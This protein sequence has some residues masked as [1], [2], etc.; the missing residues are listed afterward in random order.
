[1]SFDAGFAQALLD[2]ELAVPEG[3]IDPAGRPA[4][5][6]FDVYR[7]N[8]VASLSAALADGFPAVHALVGAD[9]FTAMAR[10]YVRAHPPSD[11]R[12]MY[13]G[14]EMPRFLEGFGPVAHLAYLPDV[15]RLELALRESYHAGDATGLDAEGL[16]ALPA[17]RLEEMR[18]PLVPAAR[19]IRSGYPVL[20]IWHKSR[21][22]N[23]P[24]PQAIGQDVLIARPG[25]DPAP[26]GLGPGAFAF[27]SALQGGAVLSD[28]IA[29]A[30]A[31]A[32][33][34]DLSAALSLALTT[35]VLQ[36][37]ETP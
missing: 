28:A 37:P 23:A 4:G 10:V 1:M 14:A 8:V 26:H 9:F 34:F 29:S 18:F 22:P 17:H 21:D 6:R 27:F 35:H 12:M 3:L 33:N 25:F 30:T 13:F 16:A 15:A 19:L 32:P 7:N 5:K 20:S 11:P 36:V 2:P 31:E 24:A